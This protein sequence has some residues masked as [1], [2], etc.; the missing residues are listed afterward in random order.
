MKGP[1]LEFQTGTEFTVVIDGPSRASAAKPPTLSPLPANVA[2]PSAQSRLYAN[3][4]C[5][6]SIPENWSELAAN[7]VTLGPSGAFRLNNGRPELTHG[8]MMGI[9][10]PATGN[11]QEV[12]DHFVAALIK[13]NPQ[14]RRDGNATA[15]TIGGVDGLA[16]VLIGK[17]TEGKPEIVTVHTVLLPGKRFFYTITVTPEADIDIYREV[18]NRV[19]ASIQFVN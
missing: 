14:M 17:G 8:L 4:F 13:G 10:Q 2:A 12:S 5:R 16:S 15:L 11:L 9:A 3:Q 7:P 19:V 6:V 1:D 18:F